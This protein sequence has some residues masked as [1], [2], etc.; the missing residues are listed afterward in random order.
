[1]PPP[2]P[3]GAEAVVALPGPLAPGAYRWRA[4]VVYAGVS[5]DVFLNG[6]KVKIGS[7]T[8]AVR[9]DAIWTQEHIG[10]VINDKMA[11]SLE[12]ALA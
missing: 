4:R 10:Q 11:K 6:K 3:P 5:G 9:K 7:P 8:K 12:K 1:M 2:V